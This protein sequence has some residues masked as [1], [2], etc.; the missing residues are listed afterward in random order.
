MFAAVF[1]V[2][3]GLATNVRDVV[4]VLLPAIALAVVTTMTKVL[5]GYLA[6]KRVGIAVPGRWRAG[7]GL[8]PH[9]EF[10]VSSR[11][12]PSVRGPSHGW[13]RWRPPTS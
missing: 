4:P 8:V 5:T 6:A 11:A 10:S 2:F 7:L 1:F 12:W 9:G 13:P 3:F